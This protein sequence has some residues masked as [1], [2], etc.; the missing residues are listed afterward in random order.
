MKIIFLFFYKIERFDLN[1]IVN[2]HKQKL[3]TLNNYQI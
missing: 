3:V 1:K 2:I